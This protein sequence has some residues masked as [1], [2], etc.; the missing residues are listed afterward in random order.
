[1]T[2]NSMITGIEVS[3]KSHQVWTA[4]ANNTVA[5]IDMNS[6]KILKMITTPFETAEAVEV[7]TDGGGIPS[8]SAE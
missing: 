4:N 3:G 1:M 5:V 6:L 8:I 2:P 7:S